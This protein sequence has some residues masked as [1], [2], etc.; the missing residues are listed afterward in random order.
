MSQVL[1]S[2]MALLV[3]LCLGL[4]GCSRAAP[5]GP[6]AAPIEV[7][8]SYPVK[9]QVTDSS[10]YTGRIAAV[11]SVEVRAR[12]SGYLDKINFKEGTL[13][14]KGEVLF[15]ID[16]R[17]FQAQVDFAKAQLVSADAAVK[18]AKA[19]NARNKFVARTPGAVSQQELDQSQAAEE[20][21]AADVEK[22]K[23]SVET[24][25]LNLGYT[26]VLSPIDGRIS[27]FNLTVGNLVT[28]DQS[29]LTTIVSVDP[30]YGYF[31][32]DERTVLQVREMIRKGKVKSARDIDWPVFLSLAN[33]EGFPHKGII[34]FVDNQVNPRTGTLRL[35]AVFANP[36]ETL[37]PGY[38]GRYRVP[39]GY[40][41]DALLVTDRAIDTDQGQKI[42]YV[43]D[44]SNK[45]VVRPIRSGAL[46][47][48][49]RVVEDGLQPGEQVVVNGIQQVRPGMA[50]EP[51][52]VDMPPSGV[53]H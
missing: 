24:N 16:P 20:Q 49:L 44:K 9:R 53:G 3:A 41:H 30:M 33:E 2:G 51:K 12:V 13:V 6:A 14:K 28:Q 38:F 1:R 47:D 29:L 11:D 4:T 27:R 31:D 5:E 22:A 34:N 15:E 23:A 7:M 21:A 46:N 37:T 48:G 40:P 42:V 39:I 17:P 36:D 45:V 10:D 26:K 32:V 8:V 18:K 25:Q 50:V 43:I 52:V 35:R 19:D